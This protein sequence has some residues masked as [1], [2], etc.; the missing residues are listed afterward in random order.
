MGLKA[1]IS[2][3]EV[4]S[5]LSTYGEIKGEVIRLKYKQGHDLAGL[6]NGNC[7]VRMVLTAHSIPYKLEANGAE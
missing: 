3:D 2:D 7:L 1:F 6:E 5:K 4:C